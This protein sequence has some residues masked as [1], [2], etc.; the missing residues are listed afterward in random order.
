[1]QPSAAWAAPQQRCGSEL[2][3]LLAAGNGSHGWVPTFCSRSGPGQVRPAVRWHLGI[4]QVAWNK[5]NPRPGCHG[6]CCSWAGGSHWVAIRCYF[7]LQTS[8]VK[9]SGVI[10]QKVLITVS[11]NWIFHT[12]NQNIGDARCPDPICRQKAGLAGR[13]GGL[14]LG[15]HFAWVFVADSQPMAGVGTQ[16]SLRSLPTKAILW[17]HERQ[18]KGWHKMCFKSKEGLLLMSVGLSLGFG[19]SAHWLIAGCCLYLLK[20]IWISKDRCFS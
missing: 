4:L 3:V 19:R 1:M 9:P 8:S 6:F 15:G 20:H 11:K 5:P 13:W 2:S 7:S 18:Q 14:A 17:F 16:W 12:C 10:L